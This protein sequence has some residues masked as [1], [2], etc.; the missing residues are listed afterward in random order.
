M[1]AAI[2]GTGITR[3]GMFVGTRLR[4]LA[5][6]AADRALADAGLDAADIGLVIVGNAAAGLLNGQEMIRAHTALADSRVAGRPML[7]VENACASSSSAVHLATL[8]VASGGYDTV[9]VVGVEKMTGTDRTA[10]GRALATA[11]DVE[12]AERAAPGEAPRP[13]FMEIYAAEARDYMRRTGATARDLATV[14]AKSYR[15]GSLNPIAQIRE[16]LSV[17]EVLSARI[18]ADPLTRPMCSSI[19]DGAAALVLTRP[20]LVRRGRP[21]VRVLA[22]ALAAAQAGDAGDVV[23]RAARTAYDQAGLGPA[24][25]DV[26]EV[27]DAAAPAELLIV[28]E[29]GLAADGEAVAMARAGVF[30]LGGR[31]PVN[32]SGGLVARGHPVGATGV[33]QIVE[34]VDQLRGRADARQVEGARTALAQNAGGSLGNGPAAC[35]V[36]MLAVL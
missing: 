26:C 24:D 4:E 5:G 14:A 32:P 27:H 23:A 28:E 8:A 35:V 7:A 1:D 31:C 33:A 19:G 36:T 6:R 21:A 12:L 29:L 34:L 17:D 18:I 30:D 25:V 20:E 10:A 13:V 9:M 3:F 2:I 16:A 22:S 11:V 15:N